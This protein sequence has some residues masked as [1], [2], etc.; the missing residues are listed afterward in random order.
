MTHHPHAYDHVS[1][2]GARESMAK[3]SQAT[4]G[5]F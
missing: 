5:F 3:E 2:V 1:K 4:L